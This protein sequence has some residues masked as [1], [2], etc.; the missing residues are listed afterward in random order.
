M[1]VNM[2]M[3]V[4]MYPMMMIV[5]FV[6][7]TSMKP[8]N[9]MVFGC[10]ISVERMKDES[11]KEIERQW[12][13]EM[14][15]NIA[16]TALLPIM[17]FLTPYASIQI[18]IW[19]L[20]CFVMIVLLE[21]PFMK[22]NAKV[23]EIK[24]GQ[25]WYHPERTEAYVELKA[26]G[27]VRR[28][29]GKTFFI[30]F[31]VSM[32][33]VGVVYGLCLTNNGL[34]K[35]KSYVIGF[36]TV[37]LMFALLNL[38]LWA[39]AQWVDRQKTEVIST[40]SDVNVNYARAKKN[41]W[42]DFWLQS[43]WATTVYVWVCAVS[44]ILENRFDLAILIGSIVYSVV[45]LG[46][47]FP[48]IKKLKEVEKFYEKDRDICE[49]DD[50]D[51]YWI[52]GMLYCN[53]KDKHTM[54]SMRNG[55]GTTVNMATKAG[56]VWWIVSAIAMLSV[57]ILCGWVIFEEFTPISLF[58]EENRVCAEHLK[59]EYELPIQEIETVTLM[60][61]LPSMSKSVGSAMPTLRKGTFRV[62]GTGERC[63]LFLNPKNEMFIR[64]ETSD[65]IYYLSGTSD[66]ETI[67]VYEK[68]LMV[69]E[70]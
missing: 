25:G 35:D 47:L 70:R 26:A 19:T 67:E 15:R 32:V 31:L 34:I 63:R 36:G 13:V 23:K 12:S 51:K 38:L 6:M 20:W 58:V 22:A 24:R 17:A 27:E 50:D 14:K 18:T 59:L 9:G 16:I 62:K 69:K 8:K 21:Y 44:L 41:I 68:I 45:L 4:A 42:K 55:M 3:I 66:E 40:Q 64:L 53:P 49:E 48:V 28:V 61:E 2:L 33:A 57:P 46:L 43:S 5:C 37:I 39:L 29:R 54:V 30:P 7:Y 11:L 60:E 52:W 56:K 65:E 1:A 10:R